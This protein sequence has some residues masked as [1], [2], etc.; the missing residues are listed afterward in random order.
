MYKIKIEDIFNLSIGKVY[1]V[2]FNFDFTVKVGLQIFIDK[3][4]YI[5]TSVAQKSWPIDNVGKR[6]EFNCW[7][8]MIEPKLFV[9]KLPEKGKEYDLEVP[10]FTLLKN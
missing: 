2:R 6:K 5:I 7:D 8:I 4:P 10:P 1:S 9:T 3:Q